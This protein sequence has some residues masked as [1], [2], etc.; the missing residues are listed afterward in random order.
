MRK[1]NWKKMDGLVPAVVQDADTGMVLMVGYMNRE[2]FRKTL[3]SKKVWFYSRSKKRLW[4]KGEKSGNILKLASTRIDCDG[5]ALLIKAHPTGPVCHTGSMT[6]FDET[7]GGTFEKLFATI[8]DR[9]KKDPPGSYTASLFK[10]GLNAILL[11]V[12]EESLEVVHAAQKQTRERVIEET[13]DL[14]YNVFVLLAQKNIH[15]KEIQK[16]ET[17]TSKHFI[18]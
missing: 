15:L 17:Y 8:Q 4:M 9:K 18:K 16:E 5:D 7:D 13:T 6:C 12:A 1:I 2:A 10:G 11:K 3:S 14:L